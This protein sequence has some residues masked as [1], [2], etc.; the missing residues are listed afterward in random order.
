MWLLNAGLGKL[1][2]FASCEDALPYAILSYV[3]GA[4]EQMFQ[5]VQAPACLPDSNQSDRSRLSLKIGNCCRAVLGLGHQRVWIDTCCIDKSSSAEL[6]EAINSMFRWYQ[7]ASLCIACLADI[8]LRGC[9]LA[10]FL[11]QA[12]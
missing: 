7:Y 9:R 1:E 2:Y 6:S 8:A 5:G 4:D 11:R 12:V 3:W 10:W